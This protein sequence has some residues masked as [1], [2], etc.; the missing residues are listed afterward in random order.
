MVSLWNK[1]PLYMNDNNHMDE[2]ITI[3]MQIAQFVGK[4]RQYSPDEQPATALQREA[5]KFLLKVPEATVGDLATEMHISMSSATQLVDRLEKLQFAKKKTDRQDR[6]IIHVSL[7]YEG[8]QELERLSRHLK[9]MLTK[10]FS[11]VPEKDIK[12]LLR[13][14]KALLKTLEKEMT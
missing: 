11:K 1:I 6:R 10:V 14:N 8:E 12:E 2:F 7:T 4:T 9:I 5:L 13:I 3:V